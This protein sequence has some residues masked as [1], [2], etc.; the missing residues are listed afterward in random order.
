M[1][2]EYDNITVFFKKKKE[3]ADSEDV[4]WVIVVILYCS[5][6]SIYDTSTLSFYFSGTSFLAS[7]NVDATFCLT[8]VT[9]EKMMI[10]LSILIIFIG[11]SLTC[12]ADSS[13]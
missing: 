5:F 10:S 2:F 1:F 11:G 9:V 6:W 13:R 8:P 12:T 7:P 4:W 3:L